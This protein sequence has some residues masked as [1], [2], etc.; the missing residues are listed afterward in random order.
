[1]ER[2][3]VPAVSG[4]GSFDN[5]FAGLMVLLAMGLAV[6]AAGPAAGLLLGTLALGGILA[7][8]RIRRTRR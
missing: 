4:R 8:V 1:M 6:Y 3:G 5:A 7:A 2:L